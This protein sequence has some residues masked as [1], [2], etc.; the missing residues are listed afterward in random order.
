MEVN[1]KQEPGLEGE[2]SYNSFGKGLQ[3]LIQIPLFIIVGVIVTLW[4]IINKLFR[5]VYQQGTQL[6]SQTGESRMTGAAPATI[7][8]PIMPIDNYSQLDPDGVIARLDSLSPTELG[9]V[10][11]HEVNHENRQSILAAIEHR[12]TGIH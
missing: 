4:E 3:F 10:K 5:L 12:L 6:V 9:I 11:N 2:S 1:I 7:K 8:V